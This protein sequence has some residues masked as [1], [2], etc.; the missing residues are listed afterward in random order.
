MTV[1]KL[2]A[3]THMLKL[4]MAKLSEKWALPILGELIEAFE[5][6]RQEL[7]NAPEDLKS[8]ME[9]FIKV[10]LEMIP[11]V[12]PE[13]AFD[14][15][16]YFYR[17]HSDAKTAILKFA[18]VE[19][20]HSCLTYLLE[21]LQ[22]SNSSML[23]RS[24]IIQYLD[25]NSIWESE[26][27]QSCVEAYVA[28]EADKRLTVTTIELIGRKFKFIL[29]FGILVLWENFTNLPRWFYC[30]LRFFAFRYCR[31]NVFVQ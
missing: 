11:M 16:S 18:S 6:V 4:Y 3:T 31:K 14:W 22:D 24:Q 7:N 30:M 8:E 13:E 28:N 10:V 26:A 27:C 20:L 15:T 17:L 29:R 2:N 23:L 12:V 9:S 1:Q 5:R 19:N 21:I 25:E